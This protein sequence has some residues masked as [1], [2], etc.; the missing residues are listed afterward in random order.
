MTDPEDLDTLGQMLSLGA[1]Y[2]AEQDEP[3]DVK[4]VAPM[5]DALRIIA[6][7]VP[8]EAAEAEP[9]EAEDE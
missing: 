2:I 1:N 8:V 6:G 5:E 9:V 7:L 3:G 4:N